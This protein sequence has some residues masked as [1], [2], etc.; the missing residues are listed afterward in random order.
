M[1]KTITTLV[2]ALAALFGTSG[3]IVKYLNGIAGYTGSP[4]ESS[5]GSCHGGGSS[6]AASI[7]ISSVPGFTNNEYIPGTTYT[8]SIDV[9]A[10]SFTS[11]GFG[12][13][14][15]N[16]QAAN[17]GVMQNAGAGVK[18][19]VS[20]SRTNAVHTVRKNGL[21]NTVNFKFEW[22]APAVGDTATIYVAANAV[23]GN[24]STSGDYPIPPVLLQLNAYQQPVGIRETRNTALAYMTLY[25]NPATNLSGI[26]Y[27]LT[28]TQEISIQ[29][30]DLNGRLLKTLVQQQE[31]PGAHSHI[32]DL[33]GIAP[34]LYFVK[35]SGNNEKLSQ[36]IITVQ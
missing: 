34:G 3:F 1:K 12:C 14:I 28:Q 32:L 10:T 30:M 29:L 2:L 21:S 13:E 20:G 5:C 15:L 18:F 9:A 26:S 17:A 25:P 16:D 22:V 7:V 6:S 19:L 11:F 35:L 23:N 24:N 31:T 36:K 4:G 8:I 33:Q 27:A